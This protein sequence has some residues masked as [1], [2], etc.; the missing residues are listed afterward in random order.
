MQ[1]PSSRE[2]NP[3][4][5][6]TKA[7]LE[8]PQALTDA[9]EIVTQRDPAAQS[10]WLGARAA[11][12][13][14]KGAQWLRFPSLAANLGVVNGSNR[15]EPAVS[16]EVPLWTGGQISASI[17]RAQKI[18]AAAVARWHETILNLALETAQTYWNIVLYSRLE[19]LYRVSLDEHQAL[20]ASMQRRVNQEVSPLADL[21]LAK[22]RTAQIDQELASVRSQRLSALH[23]L[24]ELVRDPAYDLG[25]DPAFDVAILPRDWEKVAAEAVEYSPSR[26][27]LILEA[28]SARSEIDIA[29]SGL[30]P[31]VSAQ[32]SY[33]E[34]TGGRYGIGLRMQASNGLSQ[35]SAVSSASTRYAQSLD[36]VRLVERQLRQEVAN[37]VQ[38]FDA[39]IRRA[40]ASREAS[41]TSQR[42]S[43][44]YMRQFIAGRRSWLDVMNSL[45]ES[46]TAQVGLAQAEVGAM[47]TS[48]RLQLRSGRWQPTR[49]SSKD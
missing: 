21:E 23:N 31:R 32:Y 7:P 45:R 30:F 15:Y 20:V 47:S 4:F 40:L 42:V 13:D 46:L 41:V 3:A 28:D 2:K 17:S 27:R 16:V 9:V 49:T 10:A 48:V 36:Q 37:E 8:A 5:E 19:Q 14:V 34:L 1:L 25:P 43:Q 18:E 12:S 24:A 44:S 26:A 38:I 22:S 6:W 29:K 33:N 11:L 39:S 35:L